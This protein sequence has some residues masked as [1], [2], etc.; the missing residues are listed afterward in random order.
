LVSE[1]E[2]ELPDE[3]EESELVLEL[4]AVFT[5]WLESDLVVLLL[6][7]SVVSEFVVGADEFDIEPLSFA[8]AEAAAPEPL[9]EGLTVLW[10]KPG[11]ANAIAAARV[12]A[13][14]MKP[15]RDFMVKSSLSPELG[16]LPYR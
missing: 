5:D 13:L 6:D 15:S 8:G 12:E 3:S 4:G 2:S 16:Q 1:L 14:T 11:T 9:E 7:D 10:A